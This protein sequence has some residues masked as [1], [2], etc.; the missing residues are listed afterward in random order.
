MDPDERRPTCSASCPGGQERLLSLMQPDDAAG[1]RR[2]MA[3]EG[4]RR[5]V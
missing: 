3:Y 1:M 5:A 2:L 4:T